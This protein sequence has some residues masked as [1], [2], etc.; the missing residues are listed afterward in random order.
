MSTDIPD[1]GIADEELPTV[2]A[3]RKEGLPGEQPFSCKICGAQCYVSSPSNLSLLRD[4]K[5]NVVC[6]DCATATIAAGGVEVRAHPDVLASL[7]KKWGLPPSEALITFMV[8]QAAE[9]HVWLEDHPGRERCTVLTQEAESTI[10]CCPDP[11]AWRPQ[12]E[13]WSRNGKSGTLVIQGQVCEQH[14][15][16][17]GISLAVLLTD[18]VWG[19]VVKELRPGTPRPLRHLCKLTW[20]EV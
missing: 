1:A 14:R 8:K 10:T 16:D 15:R 12:V 9:E 20:V 13:L 11:A 7:A 18:E 2:L 19:Q 4:N 17:S 3:G 6:F 5:A